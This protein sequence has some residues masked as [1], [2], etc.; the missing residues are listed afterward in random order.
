MH[1]TASKKNPKSS[2]G[3][4]PLT[5][6]FN[7]PDGQANEVKELNNQIKEVNVTVI[8]IFDFEKIYLVQKLNN[9]ILKLEKRTFQYYFD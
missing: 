8:F 3:T 4:I 9:Y 5:K 6:I 7:E 1:H 2:H